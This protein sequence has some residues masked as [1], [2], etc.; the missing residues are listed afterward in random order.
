MCSDGRDKHT[1]R[2]QRTD[3]AQPVSLVVCYMHVVVVFRTVSVT[4]A[5]Q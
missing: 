1:A 4:V 3:N 5:L 2:P